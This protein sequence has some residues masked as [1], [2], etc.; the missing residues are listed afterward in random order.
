MRW[1]AALLAALF[2]LPAMAEPRLPRIVS[3]DYCADQ[4]VLGLADP[5]QVLALSPD[6]EKPFSYF[7]QKARDYKKVRSLSEDIVALNPDIVV[8]SYGGDARTL[9]FF[10][11][12]GIRTVQIGYAASLEETVAATR[13]FAE[14]IGQTTRAEQLLEGLPA[15]A[16]ESGQSALYVTP[17]GVTAGPGTLIDSIFRHAGLGN[18]AAAPGWASVPLESLVLSPPRLAVSA[19]FGFDTDQRDHWSATRH[20]AMRRLLADAEVHALDEAQIS[21]GGWFAHDAASSLRSALQ[22][23][24]P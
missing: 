3:L 9:A 22:E 19:F 5:L 7:R 1:I 17:G 20:P 12:F 21:C 8:R 18:A 13:A 24:A 10:E 14:A 4:F 23:T 16:P 6:A 11:R 15:P 2:A